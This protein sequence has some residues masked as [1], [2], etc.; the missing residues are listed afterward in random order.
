MLHRFMPESPRWLIS[1]GKR[2]K[3]RA[4]LEKYYGQIRHDPRDTP[5]IS[6]STLGN[7]NI[8]GN[9]KSKEPSLLTDQIKGLKIIFGNSELQKRAYIT[10][11]T[12]MIASLTY[13]ALGNIFYNTSSFFNLKKKKNINNLVL[14]S[15]ERRQHL[16]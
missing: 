15:L 8:I 11:F 7:V 12:W 13:Y 4:I 14:R 6:E 16:S 1:Q 10:Y 2:K 5:C 3:A 9:E